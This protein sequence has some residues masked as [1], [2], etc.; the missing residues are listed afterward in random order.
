MQT[1]AGYCCD[2]VMEAV[3]IPALTRISQCVYKRA[4]HLVS[5]GYW[6][7]NKKREK[8]TQN[9]INNKRTES[10]QTNRL[11]TQAKMVKY[12]FTLQIWLAPFVRLWWC[13]DFWVDDKRTQSQR[14]LLLN[15]V[16][17]TAII[18]ST[19]LNLCK[20]LGQT[21]HASAVPTNK[22]DYKWI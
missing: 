10:W 14:R 22:V 3:E 19:H 13:I 21:C 18:I 6:M 1:R 2:A 4:L 17:G 11:R 16:F 15:S 7:T 5:C 20:S 8:K 9:K 12:N